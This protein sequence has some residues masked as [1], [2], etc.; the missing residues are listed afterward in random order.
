MAEEDLRGMKA[1]AYEFGPFFLDVPARRLLRGGRA[2]PLTTRL[3]DILLLLIEHRGEIVT[4]KTLFDE[5][6]PDI[7][8]EENNL[9][10]AVSGLRRVLGE[11]PK[12]HQYIETV[13]KRGYRFIAPIREID[14]EAASSFRKLED[15][16]LYPTTI[17]E[18]NGSLTTLAVLPLVNTSDDSD[19]DYLS[20]GIPETIINCLAQLPQLR[21]MAH[22]SVL[23]YKG[24][25]VD[26]REVGRE[27][28]VDAV[29]TG[30]MLLMEDRL[31]IRTELVEADSGWQLWG[32][33]YDR[34]LSDILSI[35]EEIAKR[36]SERLRLRLSSDEKKLLRKRFT[37]RT[38]AYHL[39]LRGRY[40]LNQY[41]EKSVR[42]GIEC[43]QQAIKL[44]EEYALAYTGV[45]DSYYRLSAQNLDPKEAMPRAKAAAIKAVSLDNELAEAHSSLGLITLYY[46]YDWAGAEREYKR[47]I[48]LN[49]SFSLTHMRYGSLLMMSRFFDAALTELNLARELDP[50]SLRINT[51]IGTCYYLMREWTQALEQ[52]EKLLELDPNHF[53]VH[54][55]LGAVYL[56][57]QRYKEA[58]SKFRLVCKLAPD[59]ALT[60]AFL[61][62]TCALSG[63]KTEARRIL[64]QLQARAKREYVSPY[65][66]AIIHT[67]L[68][69]KDKAF[70]WLE[71]AYVERNDW[72]LWLRV[73]PELDTLR[74]DPRFVSLLER[75][76]FSN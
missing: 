29:L 53:P 14:G 18:R 43:F 3:F 44:D 50:L 46:D 41:H 73:S 33:Q 25:E 7:T 48:E 23:R 24:R 8:V 55:C 61:G 66:F 17:A 39:Y 12:D 72:L 11:T 32:E 19:I 31:I 20:D 38:E 28:G 1:K 30:R 37:E 75:V 68:G 10:V 2:L 26:A 9:T 52:Y 45:A 40:F 59:I 5:I 36:I 22:S 47:A 65:G 15:K 69:E 70:Q 64:A 60:L 42:K 51:T 16:E 62:Y 13:P 49:H 63:K 4:K 6:W 54:F 58:I 27:L 35:Q 67:S 74:S 34:P 56:Q 76:G 57:Q 21:I 71:K